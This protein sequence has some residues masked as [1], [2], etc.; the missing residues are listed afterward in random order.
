MEKLLE[1][2]KK[3]TISFTRA[4]SV[5]IFTMDLEDSFTPTEITTSVTGWTGSGLDTENWS[6]RVAEFTRANGSTVNSWENEDQFAISRTLR[7]FVTEC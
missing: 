2:E 4:N 3:S 5:T 6:T 7:L 1:L